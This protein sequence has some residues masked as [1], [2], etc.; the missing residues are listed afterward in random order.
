MVGR[1]VAR[2]DRLALVVDVLAASRRRRCRQTGRTGRRLRPPRRE[3][4]AGRPRRRG[5]R[6]GRGRLRAGSTCSQPRCSLESGVAQVD[7]ILRWHVQSYASGREPARPSPSRSHPAGDADLHPVGHRTRR[8]M[9]TSII[10]PVGQTG[11]GEP[12]CDAVARCRHGR[13]GDDPGHPRTDERGGDL[14]VRGPTPD[15]RR[16]G[17]PRRRRDD[18]HLV[19]REGQRGPDL[20]DVAARPGRADEHASLAHPLLDAAPSRARHSTPM[21]RPTPRT[22]TMRIGR[23]PPRRRHAGPRRRASCAPGPAR[24]R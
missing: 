13:A 12:S 7:A 9:A 8:Q 19:D 17:S 18:R 15:G 2:P 11:G 1:R 21:A 22:S 10:V 14:G 24:P 16:P 23:R 4:P 20:Q 3:L 5:E 6:P